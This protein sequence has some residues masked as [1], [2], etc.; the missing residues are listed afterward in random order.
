MTGEDIVEYKSFTDKPVPRKTSIPKYKCSI[1]C[2]NIPKIN[3]FKILR[4]KEFVDSCSGFVEEGD[5]PI[6]SYIS[7]HSIRSN[8]FSYYSFVKALNIACFEENRNTAPCACIKI[9]PK[10]IDQNHQHILN[11]GLGVTLNAKFRKTCL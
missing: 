7:V 8:I 4:S 1:N 3:V 11:G 10:Y 2:T 6:A 9:N 5:I